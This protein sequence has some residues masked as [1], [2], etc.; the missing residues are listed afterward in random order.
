MRRTDL[1]AATPNSKRSEM[2]LPNMHNCF[3]RSQLELH[4][5]KAR[6]RIVH[7]AKPRRLAGS[8]PLRALSP[9]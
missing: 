5:P 3:R 4:R 1:P 9:M 7:P 8:A 6:P 2:D